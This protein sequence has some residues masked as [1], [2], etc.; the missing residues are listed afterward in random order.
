M[1]K[2]SSTGSKL[3]SGKKQM[4]E[5]QN[6]PICINALNNVEHYGIWQN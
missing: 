6:N 5:K 1:D 4:E 2:I 3:P